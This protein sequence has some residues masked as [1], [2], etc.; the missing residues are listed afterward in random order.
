[1]LKDYLPKVADD[2]IEALFNLSVMTTRGRYVRP[3]SNLRK[4]FLAAFLLRRLCTKISRTL[5]S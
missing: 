3:L 5:S 4:N 1:M 2:M